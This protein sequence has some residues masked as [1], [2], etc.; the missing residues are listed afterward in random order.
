M[1]SEGQLIGPNL[2]RRLLRLLHWGETQ[3]GKRV[4]THTPP[5]ILS[6]RF[7][8]W[9]KLDADL[10]YDNA[11]GV[12]VSIWKGKPAADSGEDIS[13]V[14]VSELFLTSGQLDLGDAVLIQWI[15]DRWYVIG[16]PCE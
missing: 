11:D 1:V 15:D 12:T 2:A 7:V 13:G 10:A 4:V 3:M 8:H 5:Q 16:T 14:I 9:G 6:Q